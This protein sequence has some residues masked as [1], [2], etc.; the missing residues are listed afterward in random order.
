MSF[1]WKTALQA[2]K[3]HSSVEIS[4]MGRFDVREKATRNKI[5]TL[6][7]YQKVWEEKISALDP[8][9]KKYQNYR[10]KLDN[11]ADEIKFLK[12]KIN[13]V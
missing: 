5:K 12:E 9:D 13:E 6:E 3:E 7:K 10:T 2:T 11:V 8:E 1:H 4:G